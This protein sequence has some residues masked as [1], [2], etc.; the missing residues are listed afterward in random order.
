M[1][2]LIE[3]DRRAAV[4]KTLPLGRVA[5]PSQIAEA[6]AFLVSDRAALITGELVHVD[7]GFHL[8]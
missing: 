2:G 7:A 4:A 1:N 3:E 6:I 8:G 5:D